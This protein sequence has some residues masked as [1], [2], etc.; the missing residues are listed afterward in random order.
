MKNKLF[1]CCTRLGSEARESRKIA[2]RFGPQDRCWIIKE[3]RGPG[4]LEAAS[5]LIGVSAQQRRLQCCMISRG[6]SCRTA[7]PMFSPLLILGWNLCIVLQCAYLE[8]SKV[9]I[10]A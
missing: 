6:S 9:Y 8:S 5:G 1:G 10:M 2:T 4:L 3:D 7:M